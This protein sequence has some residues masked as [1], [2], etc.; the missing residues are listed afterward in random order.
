MNATSYELETPRLQLRKVDLS[1]G[2]FFLRLLNEPSWLQ[3]I[4]DRGIRSIADAEAYIRTRILAHYAAHGYGMYVIQRKPQAE[5]IGLCGLVRREF[6]SGP[7][8]GF[9]LLPEWEG[10]GYA[11]ESA[12]CVMSHAH[13]QWHIERLLAIAMPG[14]GRSL[15]VLSRLGFAFEQTHSTPDGAELELHAITLG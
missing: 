9:A 6:L 1:D 7:D 15:A 5:S 2:P 14:N 13:A 12:R 10:Q 8:L 3:N 11:T 4:G